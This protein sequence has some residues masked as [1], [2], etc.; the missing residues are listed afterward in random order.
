MEKQAKYTL[1]P[2]CYVKLKIQINFMIEF[3]LYKEENIKNF[4]LSNKLSNPSFS[5]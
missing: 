5:G 1:N 2:L 3:K 4:D